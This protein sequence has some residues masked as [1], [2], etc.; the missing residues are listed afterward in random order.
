[1]K[2]SQLFAAQCVAFEEFDDPEE[3]AEIEKTVVQAAMVAAGADSEDGS[4][5][6]V[7]ESRPACY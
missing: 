1:M 7:F 5:V 4:E 3:A 6:Y 2:K